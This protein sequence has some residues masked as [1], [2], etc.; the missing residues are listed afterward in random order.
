MTQ[1][2]E[3]KGYNSATIEIFRSH[4]MKKIVALTALALTVASASAFAE[5]FKGVVSDAMCSSD[6]AKAS[7][8]DHEACATKC[9]K[10]GDKAVLIVGDKVYN[11]ANQPKVTSYAGKAV[12]IEGSLDKDTIT[13]ASI[14]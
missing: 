2:Q 6:T 8:A 12:T 4:H 10:G 9:I 7:K 3:T 11:I 14:K 1:T 13:V 5:T